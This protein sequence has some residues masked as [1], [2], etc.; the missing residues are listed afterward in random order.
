MSSNLKWN[1]HNEN[2]L[3]KASEKTSLKHPKKKAYT[4][5]I[6]SEVH[7]VIFRNCKK[8]KKRNIISKELKDNLVIQNSITSKSSIKNYYEIKNYE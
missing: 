8:K 4:Q 6:R 3:L 1:K 5:E 7:R 2:Y